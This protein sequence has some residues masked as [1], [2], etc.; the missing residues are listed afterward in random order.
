MADRKD[1]RIAIASVTRK[2]CTHEFENYGQLE[3]YTACRLIPV[4]KD[5]KGGVRPI[6]IGEVLRRII[7]KAITTAIK[8][9]MQSSA[10]SLK[11]CAGHQCGCEAAVHSMKDIF[12]EEDTDGVF[13]ID[14]N[15][16]NR[17]VLLNNIRYICPPMA[18]YICNSYKR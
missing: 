10:G 11:L 9:D 7:G 16:I 8:P 6:G 5:G 4:D 1:L 18:I 14:F 15:S 2:L 12:D 3:A 17:E 13:I